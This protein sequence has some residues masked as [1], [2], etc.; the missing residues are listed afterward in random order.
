MDK[1]ACLILVCVL[2]DWTD[3]HDYYLSVDCR[4]HIWLVSLNV[5]RV[6]PKTPYCIVVLLFACVRLA[7]TRHTY[8]LGD[9]ELVCACE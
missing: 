8:I 4:E 9:G 7:R 3:K 5:K 1:I 2:R 6:R